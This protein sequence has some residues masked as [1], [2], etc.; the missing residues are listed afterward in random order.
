[1]VEPELS[2]QSCPSLGSQGWHGREGWLLLGT[3]AGP[4]CRGNP[5]TE[6]GGQG[7]G[8][9]KLA[10]RRGHSPSWHCLGAA[11]LRQSFLLWTHCLSQVSSR[12]SFGSGGKGQPTPL[13]WARP[14]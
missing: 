2:E 14:S 7:G 9:M 12:G 11:I 13:C 8:E 4:G 1:M 5:W 3:P 10:T 6:L